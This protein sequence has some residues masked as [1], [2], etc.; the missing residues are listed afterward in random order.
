MRNESWLVYLRAHGI[1]ELYLDHGNLSSRIRYNSEISL[2]NPYEASGSGPGANSFGLEW[3]VA[4]IFRKSCTRVKFHLAAS[5]NRVPSARGL[6]RL[7]CL[8]G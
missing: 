5:P 2:P 7:W 3:Q 6:L 8:S 4:L 1:I